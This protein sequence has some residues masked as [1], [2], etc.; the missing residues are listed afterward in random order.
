[1]NVINPIISVDYNIYVIVTVDDKIQ[2]TKRC[3]LSAVT[4]T[5]HRSC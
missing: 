5:V 1:M 2:S 3:E 4:I